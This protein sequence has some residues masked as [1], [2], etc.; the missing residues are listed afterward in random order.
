MAVACVSVTAADPI[1]EECLR[2]CPLNYAPVCV[3]DDGQLL[4]FGNLCA[5]ESY[6]CEH[7]KDLKVKYAEECKTQ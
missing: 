2:I 6:N 4:N 5:L 7:K 1:P 3:E